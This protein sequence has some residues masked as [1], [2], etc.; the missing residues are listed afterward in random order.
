M[1]NPAC[2]NLTIYAFLIMPVQRIPRYKMLIDVHH[3]VPHAA[4]DSL[5]H[6]L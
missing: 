2:H 4:A 3:H 1:H 5:L 6:S